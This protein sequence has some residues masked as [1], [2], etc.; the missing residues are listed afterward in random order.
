MTVR[1]DNN[2]PA[3]WRARGASLIHTAKF[4]LT[5][6]QRDLRAS[7]LT[8]IVLCGLLGVLIGVLVDQLREGSRDAF[9]IV[10]ARLADEDLGEAG[11]MATRAAAQIARGTPR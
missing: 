7:E 5:A 1:T 4:T 3:G 9:H 6:I 8:Q 2:R 11:R 10:L